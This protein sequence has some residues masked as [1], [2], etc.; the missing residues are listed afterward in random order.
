MTPR[1]LSRLQV[2]GRLLEDDAVYR[3]ATNSFLAV[4]GDGFVEFRTGKNR[5]TTGQSLRDSLAA[6]LARR[7][8][9]ARC[10]PRTRRWRVALQSPLLHV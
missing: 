4:G 6:D 1:P 5:S 9:F 8:P 7:S 3:V 10:F 2:A